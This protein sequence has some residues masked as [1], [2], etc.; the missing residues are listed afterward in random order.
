MIV[1]TGQTY[2]IQRVTAMQPCDGSTAIRF[3]NGSTAC[4]PGTHPDRD[5]ILLEAQQSLS[6]GVPVGYVVD[7][8]GRLLDLHHAHDT[9]IHSI[10][11]DKEDSSRLEVLCWGFSPACYLTR[12]HPEFERIFATL[13]EAVAGG[14]RVWLTT[15]LRMIEGETE[16]WHK[17]MDV[18]PLPPESER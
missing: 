12:D 4:L 10:K 8:A 13:S 7:A 9:G 14:G 6:S 1:T 11:G 15:H 16:I 3:R 2:D 5:I 18:R 17:I